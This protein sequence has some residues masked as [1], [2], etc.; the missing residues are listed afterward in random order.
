MVIGGGILIVTVADSMIG[1]GGSCKKGRGRTA[2]QIEYYVVFDPANL[3][4][5]LQTFHRTFADRNNIINR[6]ES[7]E[8]WRDP[9]FEK[10]VYLC[11]GKMS[12]EGDQ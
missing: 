8:Q 12:S 4:G 5:G 7:V 1:T 2:V 3:P 6:F 10:D 9:V 11:I